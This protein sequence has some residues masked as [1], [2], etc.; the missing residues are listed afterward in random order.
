MA[1]QGRYRQDVRAADW[2]GRAVAEIADLDA[3][4]E[5]DRKQI[6]IVLKTWFEN[7]VLKTEPGKD[8]QRRDRIYVVP[9]DWN[10]A[11]SNDG[12]PV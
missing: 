11:G 10:E 6:K 4:D 3:D 2:I 5:A 7:G 1:A 12:A 8:E 9:G